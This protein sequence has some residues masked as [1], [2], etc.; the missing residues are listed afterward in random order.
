[1][2]QVLPSTHYICFQKTSGSNTGAPNLLLA[3]GAIQPRYALAG[4]AVTESWG[5]TYQPT[6]RNIRTIAE[7]QVLLDKTGAVDRQSN[8]AILC[9]CV[10]AEGFA[11]KHLHVC[12][13]TVM[14]KLH[15]FQYIFEANIT[16]NH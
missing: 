12:F 4:K 11:W 5:K 3:S 9:N 8:H 14:D 15:S 2:S 7:Q 10:Y 1:M 6:G 13:N 16:A